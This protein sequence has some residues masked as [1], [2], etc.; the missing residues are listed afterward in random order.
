MII[1]VPCRR[2]HVSINL[3]KQ[4]RVEVRRVTV[5]TSRSIGHPALQ[6]AQSSVAYYSFF[7]IGTSSYFALFRSH[8]FPVT[9]FVSTF[10]QPLVGRV[11]IGHSPPF[12]L[13]ALFLIARTELATSRSNWHEVHA[14]SRHRTSY[15]IKNV[16][17]A[18]R[19]VIKCVCMLL[20]PDGT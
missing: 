7:D 5:T 14:A 4:V 19:H 16:R 20:A 10:R 15:R 2:G 3:F 1:R 8:H 17:T 9:A 11:L 12:Q 6:G 18:R 13:E